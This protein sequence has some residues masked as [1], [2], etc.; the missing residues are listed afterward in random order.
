MKQAVDKA[1]EEYEKGSRK[2]RGEL[3]L[4]SQATDHGY[5]PEDER[6]GSGRRGGRMT[7][8]RNR[9][10]TIWAYPSILQYSAVLAMVCCSGYRAVIHRC[11]S[12]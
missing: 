10:H 5:F 2:S 4:N 3:L 6:T 8:L 7:R 9:L 11:S 12:T 1:V